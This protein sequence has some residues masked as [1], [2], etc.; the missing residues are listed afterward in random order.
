MSNEGN[1][2]TTPPPTDWD[3]T[4][5]LLKRNLKK[6]RQKP[7]LWFARVFGVALMLMLYTVG[8][9][10]GYDDQPVGEHLIQDDQGNQVRLFDGRQMAYPGKIRLAGQDNAL[11]RQVGEELEAFIS[12]QVMEDDDIYNSSDAMEMSKLDAFSLGCELDEIPS[13]YSEVCVFL[14]S[15]YQTRILFPGK[16]SATP[17]QE[18]LAGAQYA[19]N[20]ALFNAHTNGSET[21]DDFDPV[22]EQIQRVPELIRAG[23]SASNANPALV[24][25]IGFL[26][27]LAAA[28]MAMLI[29]GPANTD[30]ISE[31]V[32]SF[33]LVG[34][35]MRTYVL[36]W[37]LYHALNGLVTAAALTLVSIY[38]NLMPQSDWLLIFFSHYLGILGMAAL[39]V[40]L[41]QA[42]K[43]EE[44]A[45]GLPW[46]GAFGSGAVVIPCLIFLDVHFPVLFL[47][48]AISPFAGIIHYSAVY[49]T[50]DYSVRTIGNVL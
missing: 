39:F 6:D 30:Q 29:I 40:L 8:F 11:T 34:V 35:K 20:M 15:N 36:S 47:A 49:A 33:V 9:F 24:I 45:Q 32:R 42:V 46:L 17:F 25:T 37:C 19:V 38:Y 50:Y 7:W 48:T 43:Q 14:Q 1:P 28:I 10:V 3:H 5:I 22:V 2:P 26:H 12:T 13:A 44:L 16:E 27:C 23:E 18:P 41:S 4:L 21:M 31:V